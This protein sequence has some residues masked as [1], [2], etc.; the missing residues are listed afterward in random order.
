MKSKLGGN[1]SFVDAVVNVSLKYKNNFTIEYFLPMRVYH[2][3]IEAGFNHKV[4]NKIRNF[5]NKNSYSIQQLRKS[6]NRNVN[7][8]KRKV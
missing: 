1:V 5:L 8:K 4:N 6:Q 3:S 7:D 2:K